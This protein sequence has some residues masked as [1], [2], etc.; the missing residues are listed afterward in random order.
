[1]LAQKLMGA[2]LVGLGARQWTAVACSSDGSRVVVAAW[3]DYV[4]T[5]ADGGNTWEKRTSLGTRNWRAIACSSDGL[6]IVAA[7]YGQNIF[8]SRDGGETWVERTASGS[9]NWISVDSSSDGNKLVAAGNIGSYVYVSQDGGETWLQTTVTNPAI[10][11][12]T[13]DGSKIAGAYNS[14]AQEFFMSSNGGASWVNYY[15]PFDQSG[16]SRTICLSADGAKI[17]V[18]FSSF[19]TGTGYIYRSINTGSSWTK[20]DN[21]GNRSW[22]YQIDCSYDGKKVISAANNGYVYL[23]SSWGDVWL[24]LTSIGSGSWQSF[25]MSDDGSK[26]F[27]A[28]FNGNIYRSLNGGTS[29]SALP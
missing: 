19:S 8:T 23:S 11:K 26:I 25:C 3:G 16:Y 28:L 15:I 20:L 24:E 1:M 21:S 5:S 27:A 18:P 2:N 7:A 6:K 10:V 22:S 9:K 13:P 12:I 29:W 17:F 14:N 4:Y